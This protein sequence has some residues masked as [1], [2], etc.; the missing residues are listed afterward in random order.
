MRFQHAYIN[1]W[2]VYAWWTDAGSVTYHMCDVVLFEDTGEQVWTGSP[3]IDR[4]IFPSVCFIHKIKW[5][6][7]A[8]SGRKYC[9]MLL[10]ELVHHLVADVEPFEPKCQNFLMRLVHK[11]KFGVWPSKEKIVHPHLI[12][13]EILVNKIIFGYVIWIIMLL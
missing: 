3:R 9:G 12:E 1:I 10:L 5:W 13:T 2:A 11:A 6:E 4:D 8:V 7:M